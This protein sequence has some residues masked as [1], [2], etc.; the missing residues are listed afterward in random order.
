MKFCS[1]CGASLSFKIPLDDDRE[2]HICDDCGVVH[3]QNPKVVVGCLPRHGE[4]VLLC[5]RAIHPRKGYWTLPA[6]FLENGESSVDGALR[7]TWEEARAKVVGPKLYTVFDL[8]HINQIYIFYKAD[9]IGPS[10]AAGP[11]S[12]EVEL[13][14][15]D[16]IPWEELAFPVITDTLRYYFSDRKEEHYPVRNEVIDLSELIA[17]HRQKVK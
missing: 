5:I 17:K 11:E 1:A 2:R 14:D 3:Y 8:P 7:E 16:A 13:F 10:Y 6:G 9:L 15:E 4:Q 12:L